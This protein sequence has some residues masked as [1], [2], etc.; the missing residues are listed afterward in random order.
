MEEMDCEEVPGE[1]RI[2]GTFIELSPRVQYEVSGIGP[3][4]P[5]LQL[6]ALLHRFIA[7]SA[8]GFGV[9]TGSLQ[10]SLPPSLYADLVRRLNEA[11]GRAIVDT[12]D[13]ALCDA[14]DAQPFLIKPNRFELETLLG[15]ELD[16]LERVAEEARK[17]QR[18]GLEYVCVS[19]DGDGALL[20]GPDN[21]YYAQAPQVVV[22]SSVGAGDSMV[23]ALVAA[24]AHG[25]EA[26]KALRLGIACA[27]GTV[28]QPG[29]ELFS[30]R[31]VESYFND[32]SVKCLDI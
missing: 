2:N 31:D 13:D 9:L 15:I 16:S 32:V 29:T 30:A 11:G 25:V 8:K 5:P 27:T 26:P 4:I 28:S 6:N 17:L 23:A 1:T 10:Q 14:I 7:Y 20:V 22:R 12:H 18:R 24:F 19:M 21:S 3:D